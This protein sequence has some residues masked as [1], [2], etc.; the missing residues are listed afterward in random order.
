MRWL[1]L[2]CLFAASCN[3]KET[4][5]EKKAASLPV[6]DTVL[7]S[8]I[9]GNFSDQTTIRFDSTAVDSFLVHYP[10]F[11]SYKDELIR[12]YSP[13]K[14]A[15]AWTSGNGLIEQASILYNLVQSEKDHGIVLNIPYV[16]QYTKMVEETGSKP[17]EM[18]DLMLTSQYLHYAEN[19]VRGLPAED[20]K[21]IEWYIPRKKTDFTALLDTVLSGK[22]I[23]TR[24]LIFPQYFKLKEKL[25]AYSDIEKN[26]SWILIKPDRK[27]YGMGDSSSVIIQI[28][29]KLFLAGDIMSDN[30]SPVF[31]SVMYYGIRSFQN[32]FGL[33]EDGVAGAGVLRE[34][35]APLS[36]RIQQIVVNMERCRWLPTETDSNY[37]V[38]NIPQFKLLVYEN[39]NISLNW[40]IFTKR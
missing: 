6:S 23:N 8:T 39:N 16:D 26:G 32:R 31:D 17:D 24:D 20:V 35:A 19:V 15:F 7:P 34:L 29:K 27:K 11:S 40:G 36:K 28:R 21:K 22:K 14:Y 13:R 30:Q 25:K 9:A 10:L 2:L 3:Q 37:L 1:I 33:K 4:K 38:V 5:V 18:L 12:F